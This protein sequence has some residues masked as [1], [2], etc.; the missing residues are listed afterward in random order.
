MSSRIVN[1]TK[2]KS[3]RVRVADDGP[4][5][6]IIDSGKVNVHGIVR[7]N[8]LDLFQLDAVAGH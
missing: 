3:R 1:T 2:K 6:L 8:T 4:A 7:E 5:V